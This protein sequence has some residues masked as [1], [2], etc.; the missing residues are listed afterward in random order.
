MSGGRVLRAG[1]VIA[2]VALI[3]ALTAVMVWARPDTTAPAL[4]RVGVAPAFGH[5]GTLV[6]PASEGIDNWADDFQ[7]V[8]LPDGG[9]VVAGDKEVLSLGPEGEPTASFGKEGIK[10]IAPSGGRRIEI[11]DVATDGLGRIVLFGGASRPEDEVGLHGGRSPDQAVI[12]RLLPD[13]EYDPTFGGGDG[14][15][16]SSFGY[17]ARRYGGRTYMSADFGVVDAQGRP[18]FTLP[19]SHPAVTCD[20]HQHIE[21][22]DESRVIRLDEDGERDPTFDGGAIS[23]PFLRGAYDHDFEPL[24]DGGTEVVAIADTGCLPRQL[25]IQRRLADG[26]PDRRFGPEGVR[27]YPTL[28]SGAV[29]P[30]P[31]GGLVVLSDGQYRPGSGERT[32]RIERL[33]PGGAIDRHFGDRGAA[34]V[35]LPGSRSQIRCLVT[36]PRGR[37]YVIGT[38]LRSHGRLTLRTGSELVAERLTPD[39]QPDRSFGDEGLVTAAFPGLRVLAKTAVLAGS[40]LVVVGTG[41]PVASGTS[42]ADLVFAAFGE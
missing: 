18:L 13:G 27:S 32:A 31:D 2:L 1:A 28:R 40:R 38:R 12:E 7:A 26:R 34:E 17:S 4:T 24:P 5:D 8:P 15:V 9:L 29:A 16:R 39:G 23:K 33:T 41:H 10:R 42:P 21:V 6:V 30:D 37:I 19:A 3:G 36:D 20:T 35:S 22:G 14:V 25:L 11:E